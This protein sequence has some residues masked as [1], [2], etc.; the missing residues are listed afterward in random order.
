MKRPVLLYNRDMVNI[1]RNVARGVNL[2]GD[3]T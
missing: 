3:T 2:D 1:D